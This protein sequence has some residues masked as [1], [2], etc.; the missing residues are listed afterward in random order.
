MSRKKHKKS[1][2]NNKLE[3]IVFLTAIIQLTQAIIGLIEQL[4]E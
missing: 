2:K 1:K 4:C 3:K